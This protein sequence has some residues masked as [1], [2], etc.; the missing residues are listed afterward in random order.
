M[1][2]QADSQDVL[3]VRCCSCCRG[4]RGR[5]QHRNSCLYG[6]LF[7]AERGDFETGFWE[8]LRG[9]EEKVFEFEE[10][11]FEHVGVVVCIRQL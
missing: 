7:C 5:P 2:Q 11:V 8:G 10:D 3:T 6:L 4:L 1:L 9:S